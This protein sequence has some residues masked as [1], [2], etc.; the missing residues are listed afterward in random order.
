MSRWIKVSDRLPPDGIPVFVFVDG[1]GMEIG[2]FE[3]GDK[4]WHGI[5]FQVPT[6]W[7]PLPSPPLRES[8]TPWGGGAP[9]GPVKEDSRCTLYFRCGDGWA[10]S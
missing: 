9:E 8:G 4:G 6:H 5:N 7:A 10:R 2:R 3:P 1:L